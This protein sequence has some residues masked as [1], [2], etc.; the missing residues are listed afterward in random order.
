MCQGLGPKHHD[1]ISEIDR[2]RASAAMTTYA[3]MRLARAQ[4][5]PSLLESHDTEE[6]QIASVVDLLRR[7]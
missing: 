6:E 7:P 4:T 3:P 5:G 2:S 1:E